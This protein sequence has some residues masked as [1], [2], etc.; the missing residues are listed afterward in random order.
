MEDD[1]LPFDPL[2]RR[3]TPAASSIADLPIG[4]Q[5]IKLVRGLSD[6]LRYERDGD[7]NRLSGTQKIAAD[8]APGGATE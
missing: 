6:D 2:V 5:G 7:K 8:P 1:G 3:E 4:G